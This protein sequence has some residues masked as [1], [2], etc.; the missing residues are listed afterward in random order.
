VNPTRP[1]VRLDH[2]RVLSGR[3]GLFE[4]AHY[5]RPRYEHGY[6]LDDNGRALVIICRAAAC[7]IQFPDDLAGRAFDY[8]M[9][10]SSRRIWR[11][12]LNVEGVWES[13]AS[14]DAI[15]RAIWGLGAAAGWWPEEE[16]RERAAHRL[17]ASANFRSHWW[18]PRAYALLGLCAAHDSVPGLNLTSAINDLAS[19]LPRAQADAEWIWPERRLTYDNARLPEAFL[20][21]GMALENYDMIEDGLALLT[22]LA[23]REQGK[24]GFS[25]TPTE[26][27]GPED[28]QPGFDQQPLEAWAMADAATKAAEVTGDPTWI[29]TAQLAVSWFLGQNDK[30]SVLYD[31]G[32]GAGYDG[33]TE[34]GVNEN[35]GTEST[36]AALGAMLALHKPVGSP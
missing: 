6:C 29:A 33:L 2:L 32:S 13:G 35:Q 21:A 28:E 4:H 16:R 8:V 19:D 7:G 12:R 15:G 9:E 25:F 11:N 36:L 14:D 26:G 20:T 5:S 17:R 3:R 34:I 23:E 18:R 24:W 31:S 22:W 30:R 27:R 1:A 10:A